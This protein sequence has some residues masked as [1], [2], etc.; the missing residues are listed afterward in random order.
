M[1]R[2]IACDLSYIGE[3][4]EILVQD[5]EGLNQSPNKIE[6][7]GRSIQLLQGQVFEE[8]ARHVAAAAQAK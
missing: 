8:I 5:S 2:A 4:A 1:D 7:I 6:A 3:L